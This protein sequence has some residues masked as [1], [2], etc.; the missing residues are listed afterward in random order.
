VLHGTKP[1]TPSGQQ[2]EQMT[3]LTG[4]MLRWL[5]D[6][7]YGRVS[8]PGDDRYAAAT[9]I[10]A[11]PVDRRPR[12]VAHCRSPDD[13]QAA[14]RA[15]R[16]C[17]LPLSVRGGGHD[18]AGR[19]LCDGLVIDV[20]GMRRVEAYHENGTARI[21]GGARA[22]D[23]LGSDELLNLAAVTGSVG[24]VGMAGLTLGGGY[25]PL[26]GRFG[27]ALDN[28]LAAEVVLP[29]GRI[30]TAMP[31][32]EPELFWALRGGGGN[33]G[34][35]TEMHVRLHYLPSVYSGMLIFPFAEA[36]AVLQACADIAAS[37]PDGLTAQV[38][39]VAGPDGAPVVFAVPTWCGAPE[40]GEARTAPFFKIGTLVA[41]AVKPTS[42]RASLTAFDPFIVNGHRALIETCWLPM[43]DS[44]GIDAFIEVMGSAVSPG[45]AIFTHEFKGAAARI[46][47]SATAF[48]LRRDH[49]LIE[50]LATFPDR[51]DRLAEQRHREWARAARQAFDGI[52]LPGGYPNLLAQDDSGRA[53]KSYGRNAERLIRAKRQY[54][55]DSL[56]SSAIPLPMCEQCANFKR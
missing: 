40:E 56:F 55:P 5:G 26:I 46:P 28:L 45:C 29:D 1:S 4:K 6:Q 47:E 7:L 53:T 44:R 8:L 38:G 25:G 31:D 35:V 42:Y 14:I 37:A 51:G 30:V 11:K 17:D 49:V 15:A 20:S 48:G 21:A 24:A 22:S 39:C 43:L 9:A 13:V 18:W 12:A 3:H 19:A 2:E 54:D 16:N 36:K 32:R 50:I 52:A 27:L 41:A 34:V 33:F 23:V 10:W